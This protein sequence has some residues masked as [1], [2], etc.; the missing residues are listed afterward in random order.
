[1]SQTF[2]CFSS[3]SGCWLLLFWILWKINEKK[4][5]LR[6][7]NFFKTKGWIKKI[8]EQIVFK[9]C[10]SS[11]NLSKVCPQTIRFF[12]LEK[13]L[14][15]LKAYIRLVRRCVR[16]NYIN[17]FRWTPSLI[18]IFSRPTFAPRLFV[19]H[20]VQCLWSFRTLSPDTP[21]P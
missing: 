3:I 11:P 20:S 7:A 12:S 21:F 10:A 5:N 19:A 1:V 16:P 6:F 14:I 18:F 2:F 15:P 9:F 17:N 4:K 13:T 8:Y